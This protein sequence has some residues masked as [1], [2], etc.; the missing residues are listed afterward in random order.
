MLFNKG[1]KKDYVLSVGDPSG[2][3]LVLPIKVSG[4][5]Q[6]PRQGRMTMGIDSPGMKLWVTSP[7]KEPRLT[8]VLAEGRGNGE[9]VTE[10]LHD[11]LQKV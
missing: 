10:M 7:E 2:H 8:E 4:K 1:G 6:Q 3:F 9:W 5:L 11:Q